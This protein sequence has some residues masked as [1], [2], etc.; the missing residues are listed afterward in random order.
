MCMVEYNQFGTYVC[1][2]V[3]SQCCGINATPSEGT[4]TNVYCLT[5]VVLIP[6]NININI[7][8]HLSSCFFCVANI[9]IHGTHNNGS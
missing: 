5:L 7:K 8:K 6:I 1:S 9:I 3:P 2:A 4:V